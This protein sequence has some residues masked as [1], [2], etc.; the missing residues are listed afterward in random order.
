MGLDREFQLNISQAVKA[1][2]IPLLLVEGRL[3]L[4]H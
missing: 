3:K 4:H 1:L 2:R